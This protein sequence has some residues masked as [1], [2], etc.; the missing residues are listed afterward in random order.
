MKHKLKYFSRL[1]SIFCNLF[2]TLRQNLDLT[3]LTCFEEA[4]YSG[5]M[6][7]WVEPWVCSSSASKIEI[8]RVLR[9]CSA[10]DIC[11]KWLLYSSCQRQPVI[12]PT[13]SPFTSD[14]QGI[15]AERIAAHWMFFVCFFVFV[16]IVLGKF[17]RLLCLKNQEDQKYM[18]YTNQLNWI[19]QP[20]NG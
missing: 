6:Y 8:L 7:S 19:W 18:K 16:C 9:C 20:S 11:K 15:S 3:E 17:K 5:E 4:G 13:H 10:H 1:W 2:A 14:E 12:Q